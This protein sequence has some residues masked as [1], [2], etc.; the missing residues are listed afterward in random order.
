M[1][2]LYKKGDLL[3]YI[4]RSLNPKF[5]NR[6]YVGYTNDIQK[7]IKT[8]NK[9]KGSGCTSIIAPVEIYCLVAPFPDKGISMKAEYCL[10]HMDGKKKPPKELQGVIGK[11]KGLGVLFSSDY[12]KNKNIPYPKTI[13]IK[14]QYAHHVDKFALASQGIDV[15]E[16]DDTIVQNNQVNTDNITIVSPKVITVK[17]PRKKNVITDTIEKSS[18]TN[19]ETQI[20]ESTKINDLKSNKKPRKAKTKPPPVNIVNH[21]NGNIFENDIALIDDFKIT[22][23]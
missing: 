19:M 8:H 10:K 4:L 3:C 18:I 11:M 9:G 23:S 22:I 5:L 6:T 1:E 7:R 12:Y 15:I 14:K 2:N 20:E 21:V 13:H 16:F 17:K